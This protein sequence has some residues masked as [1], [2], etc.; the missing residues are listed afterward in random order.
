MKQKLEDRKSLFE[1][2]Y[3]YDATDETLESDDRIHPEKLLLSLR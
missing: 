3:E 1:N 2:S